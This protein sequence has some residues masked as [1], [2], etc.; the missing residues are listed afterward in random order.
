[1][2][3]VRVFIINT[4]NQGF[5]SDCLN[6]VLAQDYEEYA[7]TFIDNGSIDD[8]VNFVSESFPNVEVIHHIENI[9][10]YK[11]INDYVVRAKEDYIAILKPDAIVETDWLREMVATMAKSDDIFSVSPTI[12]YQHNPA[13][14]KQ[15]GVGYTLGGTAFPLYSGK[16]VNKMKETDVFAAG[17]CGVLYKRSIFQ[18]LNGYD[19]KYFNIG[20]DLDISWRAIKKGYKNVICPT[21]FLIRLSE[22]GSID[23]ET[24]ARLEERNDFWSIYKNEPGWQKFLTGWMIK[25]GRGSR[26]RLHKNAKK[27]ARQ[28]AKEGKATAKGL[29]RKTKSKG[30]N[31]IKIASKQFKYTFVNLFR[32]PK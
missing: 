13:R 31:N 22:I 2:N 25:W 17:D 29:C 23:N 24:R 12:L 26:K 14:V 1:M 8:S 18:H 21:S 16:N 27:A 10:D 7:V 5:L 30:L 4:N 3:K 9:G 20:G 32:F 11:A 15:A 6:A 28:G 19:E